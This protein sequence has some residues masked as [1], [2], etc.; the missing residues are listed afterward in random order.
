MHTDMHTCDHSFSFTSASL[1]FFA[2][3]SFELSKF[4]VTSVI[5]FPVT[6]ALERTPLCYE[7]LEGE[8]GETGQRQRMRRGIERGSY[9]FLGSSDCKLITWNVLPSCYIRDRRH[10]EIVCVWDTVSSSLISVLTPSPL[11]HFLSYSTD[12]CVSHTAINFMW[13][14]LLGCVIQCVLSER[15]HYSWEEMEHVIRLAL[16]HLPYSD[17]ILINI[18]SCAWYWTGVADVH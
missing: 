4:F 15:P 8:S 11:P 1:F 9:A 2:Y 18:C 6:P 3:F 16:I 5:N 12:N 17:P 10:P 14:N 7:R 13:N